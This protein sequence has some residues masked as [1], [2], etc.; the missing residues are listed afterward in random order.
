ME[1]GKN[2]QYWSSGSPSAQWQAPP[3]MASPCGLSSACLVCIPISPT[4]SHKLGKL[5]DQKGTQAPDLIKNK[6]NSK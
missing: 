5:N 6:Q 2:Q 1:N 4:S 3:G